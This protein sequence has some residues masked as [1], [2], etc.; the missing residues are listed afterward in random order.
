MFSAWT[1]EETAEE[2]VTPQLDKVRV[3]SPQGS[4][5]TA[6][7]IQMTE[8]WQRL[9]DR[10]GDDIEQ[11]TLIPSPCIKTDDLSKQIENPWNL[12]YTSI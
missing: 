8:I 10:F 12:C 1:A 5:L 4:N 9:S 7:S 11:E 3:S 2:T 6:K